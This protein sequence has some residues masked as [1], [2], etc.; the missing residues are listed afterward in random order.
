MSVVGNPLNFSET[1]IEYKRAP[2]LLGQHTDEILR[3]VLGM[4]APEIAQ[5]AAQKVTAA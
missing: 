3:E 2:P 4:D 1:P 5:L